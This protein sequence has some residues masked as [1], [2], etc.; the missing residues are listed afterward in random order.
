MTLVS[1]LEPFA[2]DPNAL[3][4]ALQARAGASAV[5]QE[6]EGV[7]Q[8][9]MRRE[10]M[11]QGLRDRAVAEVLA[12]PPFGVPPRCIAN[13][14]N[15][16]MAQKKEK[17]ATNVRKEVGKFSELTHFFSARLQAALCCG[18]SALWHSVLQYFTYDSGS[19]SQLTERGSVNYGGATEMQRNKR[20]CTSS[21]NLHSIPPHSPI[22]GPALGTALSRPCAGWLD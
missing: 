2:I 4:S 1:D 19:M 5:V 10:V 12:A 15:T 16:K 3:A 6:I 18:Q 8:A 21:S 22:A 9:V 14:A 17:A 7:K 20:S 13:K 11:L